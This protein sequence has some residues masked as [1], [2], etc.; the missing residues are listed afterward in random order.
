MNIFVRLDSWLAPPTTN[1]PAYIENSRCRVFRDGCS[2]GIFWLWLSW[3]ITNPSSGLSRT[4]Y[5]WWFSKSLHQFSAWYSSFWQPLLF[6]LYS[7]LCRE[8]HLL[9]SRV[10]GNFL[11]SVCWCVQG[12]FDIWALIVS[13]WKSPDELHW[14]K[15]KQN[16]QR[17]R[18]SQRTK[19]RLQT[20]V[21]QM[22]ECLWTQRRNTEVLIASL[23]GIFWLVELLWGH[24]Q[25]N[26]IR[27][28]SDLL[29]TA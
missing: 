24:S 29:A 18:R 3:C 21:S 22:S 25:P 9:F 13:C 6:S 11:N 4:T 10:T 27:G 8:N 17:W 1:M 14:N 5:Y 28:V 16:V 7:F 19:R 15:R 20:F 2:S 26:T 23:W 12:Q